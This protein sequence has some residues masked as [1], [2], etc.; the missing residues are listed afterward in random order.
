MRVTSKNE[1][2]VIQLSNFKIHLDE[3]PPI[4]AGGTIHYMAVSN[5]GHCIAYIEHAGRP[6]LYLFVWD[7]DHW[8][9]VLLKDFDAV[10]VVQELQWDEEVF[11]PELVLRTQSHSIRFSEGDNGGW[12]CQKKRR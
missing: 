10:N 7:D 1:K 8:Q 2:R 5:D 12:L 9:R 3:R 6:W 11:P 4:P